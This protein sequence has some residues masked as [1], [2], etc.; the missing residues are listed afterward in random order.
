[1]TSIGTLASPFVLRRVDKT[2]PYS[3]C[4]HSRRSL[5]ATASFQEPGVSQ[6]RCNVS[7]ASTSTSSRCCHLSFSKLGL[8]SRR[9]I[10]VC[11]ATEDGGGGK[12]GGKSTLEPENEPDSSDS[13][14]PPPTPPPVCALAHQPS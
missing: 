6:R 8:A 3:T 11:R 2:L 1:M 10:R 7:A 5:P 14:S 9:G 4:F 13:S 12:G